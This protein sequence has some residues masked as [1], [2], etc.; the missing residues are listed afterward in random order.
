[1]SPASTQSAGVPETSSPPVVR[2]PFGAVY[3]IV[4]VKAILSVGLNYVITPGR[5]VSSRNV[6]R[7]SPP[8]GSTLEERS[9]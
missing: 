7:Q 5:Q 1:M 2:W 8:R 6:I 3:T 4:A 9:S